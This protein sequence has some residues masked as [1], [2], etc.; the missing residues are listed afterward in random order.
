MD[1]DNNVNDGI[2]SQIPYNSVPY[3]V[4]NTQASDTVQ[5]YDP[6]DVIVGGRPTSDTVRFATMPEPNYQAMYLTEGQ[7]ASDLEYLI[8]GHIEQ[9]V[10][11]F[12]RNSNSQQRAEALSP[13]VE[14]VHNISR[15]ITERLTEMEI[16]INGRKRKIIRKDD[17]EVGGLTEGLSGGLRESARSGERSSETGRITDT[18]GSLPRPS[19]G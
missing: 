9:M 8:L 3:H 19:R 1:E 18:N 16:E 4:E 15:I 11:R 14:Y 2:L 7:V 17:P 10:Q 12:H 13:L 5:T 6:A